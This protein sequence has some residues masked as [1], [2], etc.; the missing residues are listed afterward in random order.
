MVLACLGL[1]EDAGSQVAAQLAAVGARTR[2]LPVASDPDL[3]AA[4]EE[5]A[6]A[7]IWAWIADFPDP[8]LG[9]LNTV[10]LAHPWLYRDE[11]LEEKL[12][13][14][15]SLRDQNE[16]LRIYRDFERI[17]IGEQAAVV[18][19]A[20]GES[21]LWRRP[22]VTGMWANALARSTFAHAVVSRPPL[23]SGIAP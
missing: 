6:H 8:G 11:A 21:S 20:Y 14:A 7:Y 2:L 22:W 5:R 9:F 10:L 17:W 13:Q 3:E 1:W 23:S 16:R 18:P 19:L 12:K 4:I 15:A